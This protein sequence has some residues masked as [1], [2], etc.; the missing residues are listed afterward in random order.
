M[1]DTE[2]ALMYL[3]QAAHVLDMMASGTITP[4]EKALRDTADFYRDKAD[5]IEGIKA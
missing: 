2:R 5:R 4:D 3:R 1:T